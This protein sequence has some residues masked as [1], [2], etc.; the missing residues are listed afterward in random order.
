MHARYECQARTHWIDTYIGRSHNMHEHGLNLQPTSPNVFSQVVKSSLGLEHHNMQHRQ[1]QHQ[2]YKQ[3][4]DNVNV[5]N[6]TRGLHVVHCSDS[7]RSLTSFN[8]VRLLRRAFLYFAKEPDRS[9]SPSTIKGRAA[10]FAAVLLPAPGFF[11]CAAAFES[12]RVSS[13]L[14]SNESPQPN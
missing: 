3:E 2:L 1:A 11:S 8:T 13:S 7:K 5:C 9:F 10:A 6:V 4:Q 14:I 12:G